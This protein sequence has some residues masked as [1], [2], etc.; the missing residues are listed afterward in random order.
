[1]LVYINIIYK[2]SDHGYWTAF[3][4]IRLDFNTYNLF[5]KDFY[6]HVIQDLELDAIV[7]HPINRLLFDIYYDLNNKFQFKDKFMGF[8]L[9]N[10]KAEINITTKNGFNVLTINST[11]TSEIKKE[12][13]KFLDNSLNDKFRESNTILLNQSIKT[14]VKCEKKNN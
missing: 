7:K 2:Q 1:M 6:V 5:S 3:K 11:I 9:Y 12:V 4:Y 8:I 13:K 14:L 10:G